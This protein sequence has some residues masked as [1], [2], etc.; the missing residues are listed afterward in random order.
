MGIIGVLLSAFTAPHGVSTLAMV[1]STATTR[2]MR[3]EFVPFGLF[4][5]LSIYQFTYRLW[6]SK[7]FEGWACVNSASGELSI[8]CYRRCVLNL[9]QYLP[10]SSE[11]DED[12]S[13]VLSIT[14]VLSLM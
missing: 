12:V 13:K 10:Q 2:T 1:V 14:C 11:N 4:N 8:A 3:I 9:F 7:I 5:Y 6:R